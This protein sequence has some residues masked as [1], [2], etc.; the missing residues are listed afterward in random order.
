MNNIINNNKNIQ[1]NNNANKIYKLFTDCCKLFMPTINNGH[2]KINNIPVNFSTL[3]LLLTHSLNTNEVVYATKSAKMLEWEL[4]KVNKQIKCNS[5]RIMIT[6]NLNPIFI[7][8][9]NLC[10][11]KIDYL[12][13]LKNCDNRLNKKR[14]AYIDETYEA[15]KINIQNGRELFKIMIEDFAALDN[16]KVDLKK[17]Y[18]L[19]DNDRLMKTILSLN[20]IRNIK[21]YKNNFKNLYQTEL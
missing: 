1:P 19:S 14:Q 13:N 10:T 5:Q 20:I 2:I 16:I 21:L 3:N 9:R 17:I 15:I 8:I 4:E 12:N 6:S 11:F 18:S 7:K